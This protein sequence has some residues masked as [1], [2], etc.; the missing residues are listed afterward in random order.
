MQEAAKPDLSFWEVDAKGLRGLPLAYVAWNLQKPYTEY[1]RISPEEYREDWAFED[2][3]MDGKEIE[4]D[5]I[6]PLLDEL[7]RRIYC[8]PNKC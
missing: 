3:V 2:Y 7:I 6:D 1:I 5:Q 8:Q 4:T